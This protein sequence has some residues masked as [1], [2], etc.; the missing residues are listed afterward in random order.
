MI[1]PVA[2]AQAMGRQPP[3]FSFPVRTRLRI[4]SEINATANHSGGRN[5]S[6]MSRSEPRA[7]SGGALPRA[8]G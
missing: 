7:T 3:C 4:P 8:S 6:P 5:R 2:S 1:A